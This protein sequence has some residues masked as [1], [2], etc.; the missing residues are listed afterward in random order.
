MY[1]N[2]SSSAKNAHAH[3]PTGQTHAQ[4]QLK[5]QGRA[6]RRARAGKTKR[7]RFTGRPALG[8]DGLDGS[9]TI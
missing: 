6:V 3:M 4:A 7:T 8:E 1:N 9:K 2:A 5:K